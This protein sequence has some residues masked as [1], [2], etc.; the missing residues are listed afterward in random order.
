MQDF[1]LKWEKK[2]CA[3]REKVG[4]YPQES[5]AAVVRA[6]QLKWIFFAMCDKKHRVCI[7]RSGEFYSGKV[8]CLTS[9]SENCNLSH[10]S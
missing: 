1:T 8:F 9:S 3:I 4:K 5:Y 7:H 10:P 6:I 2:I